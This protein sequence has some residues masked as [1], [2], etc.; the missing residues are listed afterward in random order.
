MLS[1]S[2]RKLYQIQYS[3]VFRQLGLCL[4]W[5]LS[6]EATKIPNEGVIQKRRAKNKDISVSL[7]YDAVTNGTKLSMVYIIGLWDAG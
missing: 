3:V 7:G 1:N 6:Q 4:S 5:I 2:E